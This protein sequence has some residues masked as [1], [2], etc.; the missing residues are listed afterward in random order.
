MHGSC[1]RP[2]ARVSIVCEPMAEREH[3]CFECG[4]VL[5]PGVIDQ[6]ERLRCERCGWLWMDLPRPVVLVLAV[7]PSGRI[8]LTRDARFPPDQWG[9]VAGYIERGER[10]E[11]AA[12]RELREETG[13]RGYGPAVV[14][15]DFYV[16]NVMFCVTCRTDDETATA[17]AGTTVDLAAPSLERIVP[18]TP[19]A[20]MI[21][22][23]LRTSRDSARGG[24]PASRS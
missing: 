8:V 5:T 11:D 15:G 6:R 20:R 14:G 13:L 12:L 18:D 16:D 21:A 23:H 24:E 4:G 22:E 2:S 9:L 1:T 17:E 7:T 19:A 3:Y 10:P